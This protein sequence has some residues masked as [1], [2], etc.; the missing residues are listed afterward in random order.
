MAYTHTTGKKSRDGTR[1]NETRQIRTEEGCS[2]TTSAM[3]REKGADECGGT[4]CFLLKRM[5]WCG[6]VVTGTHCHFRRCQ[7]RSSEANPARACY[8]PRQRPARID[9][10][11]P[12]QIVHMS[13]LVCSGE[14]ATYS[15]YTYQ[16]RSK[17]STHENQRTR[18][19]DLK[20]QMAL[21]R[22]TKI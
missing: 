15:M 19:F 7:S 21:C 4:A 3:G 10:G 17:Y 12:T 2:T 18:R 14:Y 6:L 5:R 11:F 20:K 8:R 9:R 22:G 13:L 1:R 16:C